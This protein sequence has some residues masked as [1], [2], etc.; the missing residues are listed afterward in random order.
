M[1]QFGS[2]RAVC[3]DRCSKLNLAS[4]LAIMGNVDIP[5]AAAEMNEAQAMARTLGLEVTPLE[6]RRAEDIAPVFET[7]NAQAD[8]LYVVVDALVAANRARIITFALSA[9]LPTMFNNR[10]HVQAGGLISYGPNFSDQYRRAAELVDKI[11][12]GGKARRY[13]RRAADQV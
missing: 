9:R 3:I 1:E 4:A 2:G 5:Q 7:L 8:A 6:I 10:V 11:L 13:S 12:R